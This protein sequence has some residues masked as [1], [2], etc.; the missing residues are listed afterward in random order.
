MT[1]SAKK[2]KPTGPPWIVLKLP[3]GGKPRSAQFRIPTILIG[4]SSICEVFLG[5][6]KASRN[7]ASIQ[8][9]PEG[10]LL[11]DHGSGNGTRCNGEKITKTELHQGD[12][13]RIGDTDIEVVSMVQSDPATKEK[14]PQP[15]TSPTPAKP[16]LAPRSIPEVRTGEAPPPPPDIKKEPPQPAPP[17]QAAPPIDMD[18]PTPID[19]VEPVKGEKH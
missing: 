5:D 10:A 17:P 7:H 2:G 6:R 9:T 11:T 13:I 8:R 3:V 18:A 1:K 19:G 12:V 14:A 16:V 15:A 4:R